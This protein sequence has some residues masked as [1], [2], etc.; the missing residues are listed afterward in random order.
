MNGLLLGRAGIAGEALCPTQSPMRPLSSRAW[1][2]GCGVRQRN[3]RD[4][5][6]RDRLCAEQSEPIASG[7]A[8]TPVSPED[9]LRS[10]T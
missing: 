5:G 1:G 3:R 6:E 4:A 10:R 2:C 9:G 8:P 7:P